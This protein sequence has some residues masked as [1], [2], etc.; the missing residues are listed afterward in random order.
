MRRIAASGVLTVHEAV[1]AWAIATW[2]TWIKMVS[3]IF[4]AAAHSFAVLAR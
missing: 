3:S 2:T 1:A 4:L